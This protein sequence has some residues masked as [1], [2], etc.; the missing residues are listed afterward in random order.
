VGWK[1][2]FG[3]D[4]DVISSCRPRSYKLFDHATECMNSTSRIAPDCER[5]KNGNEGS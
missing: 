4:V 3:D 1:R 5:G 2:D